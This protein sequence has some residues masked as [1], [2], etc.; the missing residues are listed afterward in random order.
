MK[1]QDFERKESSSSNESFAELSP[2]Q[3]YAKLQTEGGEALKALQS[4]ESSMETLENGRVI[5]QAD[6]DYN[7]NADD[8]RQGEIFRHTEEKLTALGYPVSEKDLMVF[9]DIP[10]NDDIES[11][12]G[13]DVDSEPPVMRSVA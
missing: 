5:G 1:F 13:R 7:P 12:E 11:A 8:M 6:K 10:A 4:F 3:K 2:A 9:L